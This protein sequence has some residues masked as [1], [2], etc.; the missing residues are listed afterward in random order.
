MNLREKAAHGILWSVIQKWGREVVSFLTFVVLSRLLAPEAFGLVALA[1]VFTVFVEMFLDQ[2]SGAAI[3]QRADLEREHLDT[4]FWISVFTGILLTAGGI[5]ASGLVATFFQEPRLAPVLSWLSINFILSALSSTQIAILQRKMAFKSLAARSL[6]A[7]TV[8]GIVGISM[9]FAGFGVW[10]LVVQN[11][12]NGLAGAIVLWQSSNWRP[13]FNVSRKH[14]RDLFS[15]GV[16][17]VGNNILEVLMRRSDDF[18]IGYYLGPT[19]LGYYTIGYRLLLV[20]IRVVT[21]I[22]NA[23][24]FPAFS[25]LQQDPKRMLRAFYN[26]TQYTSLLAFPVFIGMATLAPELVPALF[27]EKWAPSIPVMQVLALI[28][29]LQSVLFFNGSVIKASG[30]PSWQLGVMLLNSVCSVIGFLLAVRWGI[31]TVAASY[32][33]VG[34]LLAP[35]SY[36]AVRRLIQV[37]FRTYLRQFAPPLSASLVMVAVIVGLKYFFRDQSL[38]LY[39]QLSIYLLAAVLTYVLVIGLTAR[40]LCRQVLGLVSLVLPKMEIKE[41]GK[42]SKMT[43]DVGAKFVVLTTNRSGSE[44]VM[45]TLNS[46]PHVIAQGELFLP[47]ARVSERRWD[48]D[49]ACPRFIETKSKGQTF[50]PF[51]VFS[52]LNALYSTPGTVGFKLMYEQLGLYPEILAYLI[53]HRVRVV[54]L[55]RRNHLD[56]VLSYAVK[57]KIGRAHLL[58]GQSAPDDIRVE[59]DTEN[60]VSQL[61]WL[62]KKQ[63]V[64][65]KLLRWCRLPHVEVAYEDLLRDPAHFG[66]IWDFLSIKS[67]EHIPQSTLLKIRRGGQCDVISNYD[68]VK[69]VLVNSKFAELVE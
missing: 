17:I 69:E 50:R 32:V 47:R 28:G 5:A 59:L 8:G 61:E 58:L 49:F 51:S 36:V 68:E 45:S 27:G 46:L 30:K 35:V 37:D 10:S 42:Y 29:I 15:F 19:L 6:T 55:V 31:V 14:Y 56:V 25:R 66:P 1:S 13:G 11:L 60:L 9:A 3:V 48:S 43:G 18:L 54:H 53:R 38:S 40:S 4:A 24:A 57:A 22:T 65:R 7:T 67:K 63:S 16:S 33:I 26:V 44:W 62:Q 21:G 2:G 12:A 23:V 39:P 41:K 52:Y 34:Y 20:I 64:A